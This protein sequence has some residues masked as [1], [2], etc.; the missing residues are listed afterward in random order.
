MKNNDMKYNDN[1]DFSLLPMKTRLEILCCLSVYD[2]CHLEY[3]K[4]TNEHKV[5]PDF[6]ICSD[7]YE[8]PVITH[9]FKKDD[10]DAE[11]FKIAELLTY[12]T[13]D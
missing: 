6:C 10:F 1:Y 12:G 9:Y 7:K 2:E 11:A 3:W 13:T 5:T 4:S 8:K